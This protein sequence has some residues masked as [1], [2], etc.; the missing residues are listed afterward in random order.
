MTKKTVKTNA[1]RLLDAAKIQFEVLTYADDFHSAD[2]VAA[3]IGVPAETV[4]KTLVVLPES[5]Q[6]KPLLVMIPAT[7]ELNL[8]G[9]GLAVG[10]KKLRMATKREA[11]ELTGL[12][13]GGISPL[14]LLQKGFRI[15]IDEAVSA[16]PY[17]HV[18]AGQR[19]INLRLAPADLIKVTNAHPL[20]LD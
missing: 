19:G 17:V 7:N 20:N 13:I 5:G 1:M 4:Y 10:E 8:K 11:E 3:L 18:S 14:A 2:E 6:G 9:L 16:L 15:Y 12:L